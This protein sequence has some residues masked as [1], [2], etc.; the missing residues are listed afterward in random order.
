MC[1]RKSNECLP[2]Q[3][4]CVPPIGIKTVCTAGLIVIVGIGL[5][6]GIMT[7]EFSINRRNRIKHYGNTIKSVNKGKVMSKKSVIIV[8]IV[9]VVSSSGFMMLIM[10]YVT[11]IISHEEGSTELKNPEI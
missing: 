9:L 8:C 11:F 3:S 5:G 2:G 6:I 1:N 7:L 10:S 4:D